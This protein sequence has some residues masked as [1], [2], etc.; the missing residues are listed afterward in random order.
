MVGSLSTLPTDLPLAP[1]GEAAQ[2]ADPDGNTPVCIDNANV[3]SVAK[4]EAY[5][6]G[7]LEQLIHDET[8]RGKAYSVIGA[9]LTGSGEKVRIYTMSILEALIDCPD[10]PVDAGKYAETVDAWRAEARQIRDD[11]V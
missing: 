6:D 7:R 1:H 2:A 8:K 10:M 3:Y 4:I 5:Y 9:R 11:K